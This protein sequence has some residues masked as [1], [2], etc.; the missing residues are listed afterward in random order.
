MTKELEIYKC[1]KCGN[2]VA[3]N[4]S[5]TENLSCCSEPM[6]LIEDNI[7]EASIEK[8]IP[9]L[10][11]INENEY[12][13]F[14]GEIEH[15]MTTEHYIEWIEVITDRNSR[16]TFFLKPGDKPEINFLT[17]EKIV[18]IKAYCNLH[19]LWSKKI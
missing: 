19:G 6:K 10:S 13:I 1:N 16:L 7:I 4:H 14:V 11:K 5:G 15:P 3:I 2:I 8:H 18:C 17:A 9:I 12:K